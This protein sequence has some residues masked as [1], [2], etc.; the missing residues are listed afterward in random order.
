MRIIKWLFFI[1]VLGG[2]AAVAGYV[3]LDRV[4]PEVTVGTAATGPA[5]QA[6]Y[7]TGVVEPIV[8]AKVGPLATGR[9]VAMEANEGQRVAVGDILARL[10][11]RE[12]RARVT[13]LEARIAYLSEQ[14]KRQTQ[15][16]ETGATSQQLFDQWV[17]ELA[18]SRAALVAAQKKLADMTL[19][20]PLAGVVLRRDGEPGETVRE[21]AT[22]Y[23][24]GET[25]PLWI[26]ADVDEDDIPLV[27]VGQKALIRADAYPGEVIQGAIREITP[28]G[29]PVARTYRVRVSLPDATVLRIG[30][31]TEVNIV[32]REQA[33]AVLVPATAVRNDQVF[34]LEGEQVRARAVQTGVAGGKLVE[35]RRGLESG[36][37]IVVDPPARLQDGAR[38]RLRDAPP[39]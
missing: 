25:A 31:T 4:Y 38:V 36:T 39:G 33:D 15:L 35:I 32:V 17:S 30:M 26:T 28:K 13:E 10:D 20:S 23:W 2:A 7:A 18:Q 19:R 27:R 5:V 29:D 21:G 22:L 1:A 12:A 16:R 6:V 37:R 11:D 34:V 24:V 8:W 3:L 9:I 14:V